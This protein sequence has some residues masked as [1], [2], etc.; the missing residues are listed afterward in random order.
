MNVIVAGILWYVVVG[1]GWKNLCEEK[2]NF[3]NWWGKPLKPK[4]EIVEETQKTN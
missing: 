4:I 1:V 3:Q 2:P